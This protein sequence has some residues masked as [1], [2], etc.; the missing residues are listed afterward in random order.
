MS[1]LS[2][3]HNF[4]DETGKKYGLLHVLGLDSKRY[5]TAARW[6]C[7]CKGCGDVRSVVGSDLRNGHSTSCR[8]CGYQKSQKA[9]S[10]A[11]AAS[12]ASSRNYKKA[13]AASIAAVTT[14]GH[15]CKG[16]KSRTYTSWYAMLG[17]CRNPKHKHY[18]H[19]G[20]RGVYVC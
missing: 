3:S 5:K 16:V 1:K 8:N 6:L 4:K 7:L 15:R 9:A 12:G 18:R 11:A 13:I 17:R 20:G 2:T 10:A 19:Y 14:H